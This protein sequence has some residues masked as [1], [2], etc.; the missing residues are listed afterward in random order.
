[1]DL[2]R[3]AGPRWFL[4]GIVVAR[5][6][7]AYFRFR[8][9]P[10]SCHGP[11]ISEFILEALAV[12]IIHEHPLINL[13]CFFKEPLRNIQFGKRIRGEVICLFAGFFRKLGADCTDNSCG[14]D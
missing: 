1:M 11:D 4:R 9:G 8:C 2:F 5:C 12:G 6:Q 14:T 7:F 13:D 10:R 3:E